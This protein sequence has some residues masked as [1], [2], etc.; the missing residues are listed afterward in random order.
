MPMM[1]RKT[2]VGLSSVLRFVA[3]CFT[4]PAAEATAPPPST[5]PTVAPVF[6][7]VAFPNQC[8]SGY[9]CAFVAYNYGWAE[10]KFYRCGVYNLSYWYDPGPG[11]SSSFVVDDQTGG[12]TTTYYGQ[13][14]NVL[15][16]MKPNP[17]NF[18]YVLNGR[19]GWNP[20]YSIRVC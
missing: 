20:V 9:L 12:V 8:S 15:Q 18:Q 16:T 5:S 4:A 1:Q 10:F 7:G 19:G 11:S 6:V 14:G 17:G 3:A 13:S 2:A